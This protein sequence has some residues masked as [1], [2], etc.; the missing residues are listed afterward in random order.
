MICLVA[1]PPSTEKKESEIKN[2]RAIYMY[3]QYT[4]RSIYVVL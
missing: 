2:C 4:L 1:S 3:I